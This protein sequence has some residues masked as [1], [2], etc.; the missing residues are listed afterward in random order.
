MERIDVMANPEAQILRDMVKEL[1]SATTPQDVLA[2]Y[3]QGRVK[4]DGPAGFISLS[5]RDLNPG[6]YRITRLLDDDN[7]DELGDTDSWSMPNRFDVQ[8]GGLLGEIVESGEISVYHNVF[9]KDDPI[10]GN[11]IAG[12]GS[13][14]AM[15]LYEHGEVTHWGIALSRQP[16]RFTVEIASESI[17]RSNLV[18][19]TVRHVRTTHQLEEMQ[20]T[21]DH[22]IEKIANIQ[23]ALLPPKLPE[24]KGVQLSVS[25][26]TF[27]RAGGDMYFIHPLGTSPLTQKGEHNGSWGFFIGDVSGHGPA[28]A[29]VMAMV[30]TLM[31]SMP[32]E[33]EGHAG[34]IMEYLNRNLC[35]T[36]ISSTF[37]TGFIAGLDPETGEFTYAR[38]GHPPA[39]RRGRDEAGNLK[40]DE[41]DAVGSLPLGL[42]EDQ[43][44]EEAVV[45]L[46]PGDTVVL[47]TDGIPESRA[48]NGDFFGEA[49]IERALRDC[50]G[51]AECFVDTLRRYIKT[52]ESGGR[53]MD[54][55][56]VLAM[57]YGDPHVTE[58]KV[59]MIE[60]TL[61]V[62]V[63]DGAH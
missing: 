43:E 36:P 14:M 6:E 9:L 57:T 27:D 18:G 7:V 62:P 51:Y 32:M 11:R 58:A 50:R 38:A 48:P 24:I 22:E 3:S 5:C 28:A 44:Y 37:V 46:D 25:Y 41:F 45:M 15:P 47:Y 8:R 13:I 1:S 4:L 34:P 56:T 26:E 12:Y 59:Q 2:A 20:K 16:E 39:I 21:L 54:D 60:P 40:I 19:N 33:L 23:K 29:V 61:S 52:H 30:S 49:G 42:L 10:L 17:L 63:T 55:Q 35:H 53:P 31:T